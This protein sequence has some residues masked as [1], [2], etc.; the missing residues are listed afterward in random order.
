MNEVRLVGRVTRDPESRTGG[1]GTTYCRLGIACSRW[2]PGRQGAEGKEVTDF[3]D[4]VCF[5]GLAE[6]LPGL[7]PR[8]ALVLVRGRLSNDERDG[9]RELRLLVEGVQL[10]TRARA[11]EGSD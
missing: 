1:S 3:L 5:G 2:V 11:A 9:R 8:G 7:A 6:R 10:L 4:G